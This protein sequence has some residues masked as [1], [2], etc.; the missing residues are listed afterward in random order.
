MVAALLD[1]QEGAGPPVEAVQRLLCDVAHGHD[2]ADLHPRG[3]AGQ[4]GPGVAPQLLG[5]ADQMVDLG[6]RCEAARRHLDS[7]AGHDDAAAR[8]LAAQP[9]DGLARLPLGLGGDRAGVDD[10]RVVEGGGTG[11]AA[12]HLRLRAC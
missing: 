7:A 10:H 8:A 3:G 5:V 2:I 4:P 12:H 11:V 9:A 1:Q 6:H